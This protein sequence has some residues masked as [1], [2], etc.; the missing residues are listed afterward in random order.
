MVT[1]YLDFLYKTAML[2]VYARQ[3][4]DRSNVLILYQRSYGRFEEKVSSNT[5]LGLMT[6]FIV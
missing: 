6:M 2:A 4:A 1:S 3:L 5:L